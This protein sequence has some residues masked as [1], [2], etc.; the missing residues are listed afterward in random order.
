MTSFK[1]F[2]AEAK[3]KSNYLFIGSTYVGPDDNMKGYVSGRLK[4]SQFVEWDDLV[5]RDGVLEIDG[6]PLSDFGFVFVGM[7]GDR[8][9]LCSSIRAYLEANKVH[10]L[11]YGES[12]ENNNKILQTVL[13]KDGGVSQIATVIGNGTS[14]KASDLVK[15]L[16]LPIVSKIIDGSQGKGV[17]KHDD[18]DTLE[19][20]LKKDPEKLYI[21]QEF[22]PNEGDYRVFFIQEE[23]IYVILRKRAE[24][25]KEFRNNISLGGSYEM[26]KPHPADIKKLG[27]AAVKAMGFGITGVDIIKHSETG[28]LYVMEINSAPQFSGQERNEVLDYIIKLVKSHK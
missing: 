12:R 28:K 16:K 17:V 25:K 13:M 14:L 19:K 4:G 6:R 24:G 2:L 5:I 9:P 22:V 20:L 7:V 27:L 15:E 8:G 10:H 1:N 23:L 11:F 21:F 26:I 3:G 18:V